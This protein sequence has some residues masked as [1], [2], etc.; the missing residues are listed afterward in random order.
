MNIKETIAAMRIT[1]KAKSL[2]SVFSKSKIVPI[3]WESLKEGEK[4]KWRKCAEETTNT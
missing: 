1:L 4:S 3:P 2:Y